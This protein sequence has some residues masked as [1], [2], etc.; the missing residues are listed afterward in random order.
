MKVIAFGASTS[1]KSLNKEFATWVANQLPNADVTV[2]DL[3]DYEMPIYSSDLEAAN[4]VPEQATQFVEAI[5][6]ADFL[7]ISIAEH[8]GAYTAA[9]KNIFDW[10]SRKQ[11]KFFNEIPMLLVSTS[12][13][14]RGG[15]TALEIAAQRFPI[16]GA[17]IQGQFSLPN[18]KTT[19]AAGQGIIDEAF[20]KQFQDGLAEL[21]F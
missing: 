15:L 14:G 6:S 11:V 21:K 12:P 2:L 3:N 10:A 19:F 9:F 7:V 1:S 8:N 20:A 16:H 17:V 13:G 5:Q 18:F 4:G